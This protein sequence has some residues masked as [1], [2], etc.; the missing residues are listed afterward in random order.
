MRHNI[1]VMHVEKNVC[2]N[3]VNTLLNIVGKTKDTE[4]ARLDLAD[5]KIR[6]ELHLQL[7]GNKLLK[8]HACYTLTLEERR[9]FCK[10]LKSVKFP[11][12]Y[13]ANISRN[14]NISD[15]KI[16]GLKSHDCHVLHQRLLPVGI[17]P[18]L[19]KDVCDVLVALS[20]F[21][22]KLCAKTL[23]VTDLERLEDGIVIILCKL[24]RIFPPAFF[25]IMIHL[26]VHLPREAKLAGPVSYRWM[27][28][29]E[30]YFTYIQIYQKLMKFVSCYHMTK[31]Y[32]FLYYSCLLRNLGTLKKYVR[33]KAR[34]EG[35][36]A[37]AYTVNEALTFCSMYLRGIETRF[38]RVERNDDNREKQTRGHLPIFSQQARPISGRQLVQL[39]KEE[40]EK[41]HWY[42]INNCRELQPY[43]E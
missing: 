4:K 33:N 18:Y 24:E 17:R 29:F 31:I 1:D 38:S 15:G 12:G 40:L 10:F 8:P 35:S 9:E 20:G 7:K 37:E 11:N 21:F 36:I 41:A 26:L 16:S 6:N 2:E 34:P 5:M 39:S 28:P 13:A 42:V 19:N 43:L 22:Q 3:V 25:D 32:L 23:Y 27:Y 30:S 14:V